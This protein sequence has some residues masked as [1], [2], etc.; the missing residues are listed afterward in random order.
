MADQ[1]IDLRT[2][3]DFRLFLTVPCSDIRNTN[4]GIDGS[5][6]HLARGLA[7]HATEDHELLVAL[8]DID[9]DLGRCHRIVGIGDHGRPLQQG[10]DGGCIRAFKSNL[11]EA[12]FRHLHAGASL[13][14]LLT[15]GLHLGHRK[16]GVV[17]DDDGVRGLKDPV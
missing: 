6:S 3:N 9:G 17:S 1:I 2:R 14:R 5:T 12:V 7:H 15:Q 16:A 11:G 10:T 8:G 13:P 4:E